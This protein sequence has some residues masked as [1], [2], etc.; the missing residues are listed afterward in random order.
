MTG[1]KS[2]QLVFGHISENE[3]IV[4]T[5][6]SKSINVAQFPI[7]ATLLKIYRKN[8]SFVFWFY[9]GGLMSGKFN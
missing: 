8:L 7:A 6:K 4:V 9:L 1:D 2:S 5:L 3:L